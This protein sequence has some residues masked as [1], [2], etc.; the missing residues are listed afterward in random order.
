MRIRSTAALL[1]FLALATA[2]CSADPQKLKRQFVESGDKYVAQKNYAEA[3]VQ[4]RNA[5]ARDGS[6]GEGRFKLAGAYAETGDVR[7]AL[8][9]YV[10]AA[11][12]MP[13]DLDAQLRA[14][15]G[16]LAAGQ[17][18]E[19][20]ARALAALSIDPKNIDGLILMG[21]CLA[22]MRDL[23]G[24]ISE[25][26]NAIET[27]PSR[28][29]AYANLGALE[30]A[31]GNATAAE[32]AFKRAVEVNPRSESAH[33][34]MA[35]YH[36]AANQ[37]ADAEREFK[38]AL[39]IEPKSLIT[40]RA[41]ALFYALTN[42]RSEGERYLRAY[43][44]LSPEVGPKI[45]LS[46]YYLGQK[47]TAEAVRVLEPLLKSNDGFV[48]AKLRL[49]AIDFSGNHRPQAYQAI[50]EVLK[51]EPKNESA[52]LEKGRFLMADRKSSEALALA[53]AAVAGNPVSV[54]GHYLK[55]R[56]LIGVGNTDAALKEFQEVL[57]LSPSATVALV[58]LGDLMLARGDATGAIEFLNQAIKN[59]PQSGIAHY[60]LA[61]SFLRLGNLTRA[62]PELMGLVKGSPNSAEVHALLGDFYWAKHDLAHARESYDRALKAQGGSVDAVAGLVRIELAENKRAAA[63]AVI[64][65]QLA[66]TP[67]DEQLLLVAGSTFLAVGEPQRAESAF[68]RLLQVNPSS[69]EAYN[70]LGAFYLSEHRLDEAR[71]E[72][73]NLAGREPK[74]AIAATTMVGMILTLQSQP[75]E[76]RQ[77]YEH[78]LSLDPLMPVAANNLAWDY[79]ENG[80]NLDMALQ[81]AQTAKAG[82]PDS[83]DVSDT[84]GWI[85]YK[86]GLASLAIISLQEAVKQAPSNSSILYRLGLAYVKNGDQK[87]A[88]R[89]FERALKMNPKFRESDDAKRVLATLRG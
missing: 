20:K 40:N 54:G 62:Q 64:E 14:G 47:N 4:Y 76:A 49:A 42:R 85:Y 1:T 9:E 59:Q 34:A 61:K 88:R 78:V 23:D 45:I 56:A 63:R 6:F 28:T 29:L 35:N 58:K 15:M 25:I 79:A 7:N 39:A 18:P 86:K 33:L 48:L 11:D 8:R 32:T 67:D 3:I 87:E 41:L 53:T 75:D 10:R 55:G 51:R 26:E 31:R 65:S 74:A 24:A 38:A 68:R 50:D 77:R 36:W 27:D 2:S 69:I 21:N 44:E 71:K 57:R 12:L 30:M 13:K 81:L 84:L 19:A 83:A 66:K 17:F 52:L 37:P 89:S 5:V 60:L 72:Y 46:D 82:L 16:L 70:R 80:R 43:A 73:E 22:G